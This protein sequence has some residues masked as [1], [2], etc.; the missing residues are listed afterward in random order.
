[1]TAT[2]TRPQERASYGERL[3]ARCLS[4]RSRVCLGIDPRPHAHP[5]T[6]PGNSDDAEGV[7]ESVVRFYHA[8][9]DASHERL[10]CVKPQS[11]FFE[12]L[13]RPG[14]GALVELIALAHRLGLPVILDAKRG[15]I[16]TTAEAYASAYLG[17]GEVGADA[18]TVSPYLGPDTLEPF[19]S[20]ALARERAVYTLV[21]TSNPGAAAWQ[22][23]ST[24]DGR[25]VHEHVA[26]HLQTLAS[27][28]GRYKAVGAVVGATRG[29]R[30]EQLRARMP[31]V[32]LLLPGYG[33][34]GARVSDVLAAFDADGTGAVVNA[35]RSLV[36]GAAARDLEEVAGDA[37]ARVAAMA[38]E[39]EEALASRGGQRSL[40]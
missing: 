6:D 21:A 26:D 18:L 7:A 24:P 2:P 35:S 3:H 29:R 31:D 5:L 10:A 37:R 12:A 19:L 23:L 38:D 4:A 9:L 36:P 30:L 28:H 14:Q 16:G 34:Q 17:D 40:G 20:R 8:I 27:R 33:A 1:M 25:L 22:D 32:L 13:G 11:A 39:L 15:D